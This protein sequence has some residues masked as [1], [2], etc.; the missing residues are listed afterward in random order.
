MGEK[1]GLPKKTEVRLKE[2]IMEGAR[3]LVDK[4][5]APKFDMDLEMRYGADG[6]PMHMQ[7]IEQIASPFNRH[8]VTGELLWFCNIHNHARYLR[9]RRPCTG[10]CRR[11]LLPTWTT[12][13]RSRRRTSGTSPCSP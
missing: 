9:D 13:T 4:L 12:S 3:V 10:T 2:P 7:A 5:V 8:P 11:S 1:T 6:K